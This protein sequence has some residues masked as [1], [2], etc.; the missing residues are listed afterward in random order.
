MFEE[1]VEL[2]EKANRACDL[3]AAYWEN[4]EACLCSVE[5]WAA[6]AQT[7]FE[8]AQERLTELRKEIRLY[9]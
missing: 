6:V 5:E 9:G 3:E 2:Q 1:Y 7:Q 8:E 4:V